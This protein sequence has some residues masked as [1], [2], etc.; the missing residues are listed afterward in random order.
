L[1]CLWFFVY[2]AFFLS[3]LSWIFL[4]NSLLSHSPL[5]FTLPSSPSHFSSIF[6]YYY[7]SYFLTITTL[8][9]KCI[10]NS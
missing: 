9:N 2:W 10:F 5:L 8:I 3:D 7:F 4:I 1:H 6:C